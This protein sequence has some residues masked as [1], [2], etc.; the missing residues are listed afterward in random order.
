MD[1]V[2]SISSIGVFYLAVLYVS[3]WHLLL[4]MLSQHS[5]AV[6]VCVLIGVSASF[7]VC[8]RG[9]SSSVK[10]TEGVA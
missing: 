5:A 9:M 1:S 7:L 2:T 8:V 4:L 3:M 10:K 6:Y